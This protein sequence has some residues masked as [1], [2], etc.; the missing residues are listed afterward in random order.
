MNPINTQ[1]KK[2]LNIVAKIMIIEKDENILNLF[3]YMNK[4]LRDIYLNILNCLYFEA[5]ALYEDLKQ[6]RSININ[7]HIIS[8]SYWQ[9]FI[10][11]L[12]HVKLLLMKYI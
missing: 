1:M 9:E 2:V 8:Q 6:W 10:V 12:M 5:I 3:I 7:T 4:Q 11:E